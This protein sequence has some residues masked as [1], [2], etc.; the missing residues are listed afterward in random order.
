MANKIDNVMTGLATALGALVTGK[1]LRAVRRRPVSQATEQV[2]PVASVLLSDAG[3]RGV[4]W[5][6]TI[7]VPILTRS[8]RGDVDD[9][10][11][12]IVALVDD[13]ITAFAEGGSAGGIIDTPR[14]NFWYSP[15][16]D[17]ARLGAVAELRLRVDAPLKVT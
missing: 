11:L 1:V 9:A 12:E 6:A 14:W 4:G 2:A 5:E 13:A 8:S 17:M 3:R 7:L 10:L 16:G 15:D